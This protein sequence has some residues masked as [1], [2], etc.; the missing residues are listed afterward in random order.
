M[1]RHEEVLV[2][3]RRIIRAIDLQSRQLMQRAGLTGPQLLTLQAILRHGPLGVG[4][5]ARLVNLSQ[6]TVTT[7]LDRL[8]RKNLVTRSRSTTDK[9]RVVVSLSA[10]GE[11]ALASAPTL[12]QEHFI[13][14]FGELS[15]WEQNLILSSLQRVAGMM[16]AYKLDAAPVLETDE[17]NS[18]FPI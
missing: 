13:R 8:E 16:D 17:L 7:I 2:A 4:E 11:Q 9:R 1:E 12:L 15:D 10:D 5:L 6:G 3:L 18:P 14:A